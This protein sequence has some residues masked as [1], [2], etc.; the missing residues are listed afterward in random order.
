MA[1]LWRRI[2]TLSLVLLLGV[3]AAVPPVTGRFHGAP[4]RIWKGKE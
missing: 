4:W 3:C 1:D 2:I